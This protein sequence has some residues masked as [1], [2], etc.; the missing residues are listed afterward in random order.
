VE[1]LA[2]GAEE[3][4]KRC[5]DISYWTQDPEKIKRC[6]FAYNAGTVAAARLDP[7]ESAYV[8]NNYDA[9]HANMV[10]TDVELGTVQ[11]TS[12]GAWP[13]HL[14]FQSLVV[15]QMDLA[16]RPIPLSLSQLSTTVYDW[17]IYG[18]TKIT[19][20]TLGESY[21]M[22]FPDEADR[23]KDDCLAE[24]HILGRLSLRPNLNPVTDS[25]LLTQDIHGCSYSLPG[26]DIT[27]ENSTAVLQTPMPGTVTTFTDQWQNSTIRIENDEWIVWLLHPRSY[28]VKEGDVERGQAV[29]VMGSVG[30][31]TGPH[32]HYTIYDKVNET[33]VDP[34]LFLP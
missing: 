2:I 31:S 14:A 11:V 20:V 9:A 30:F 5:P 10:Y 3:F 27:S 18:M 22:E 25:P 7:E 8:M 13:T 12:L 4:K 16:E 34:R 26:M 23:V 17:T 33:F 6:Y 1:Q 28:L 24:P 29:G 15:S 21:Q 32:V 19:S